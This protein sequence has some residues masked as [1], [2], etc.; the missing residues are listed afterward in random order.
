MKILNG[1]VLIPYDFTELSDNAIKYGIKIAAMLSTDIT[2]LH[3]VHSVSLEEQVAKDLEVVAEKVYKDFGVKPKTM[4]KSGKVSVVIKVIAYD[5]NASLVIMKTAGSS[6]L[7]KIVGSRAI[8]VMHKSKIPFIVVQD[9][10][11]QDT[12]NKIVFPIDFR[13]ENKEKLSW[14]SFI[15]HFYSSKIYFFKPKTKDYHIRNNLNFA[16]KFLEGRNID[17]EIFTAEKQGWFPEQTI[18]F[19]NEID[20]DS[21][22]IMLTRYITIGKILVG[23]R[24]QLYITNKYK[25]PVTCLNP[26]SDL[27]RYG[28]FN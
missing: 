20:A 19:A 9:K 23:L 21:I 8:K 16:I 2:L 6:G 11:P 24:D 7:Q 3:V 22:V 28:G 26:R 25:I 14:I 10:P 1:P 17:F 5:I 18:R 27:H 12:I 15:S 4:V 13:K